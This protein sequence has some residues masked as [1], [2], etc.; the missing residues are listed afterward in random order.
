MPR[1]AYMGDGAINQGAYHE[2]LNLAELWDLPVIYIIENNGYSMGT[3]QERSSAHPEEGL[4]ASAAGYGI[5]WDRR[6][7]R[8]HLRSPR[9][10]PDAPSNAPTTNAARPSSSSTPTATTVTASLMRMIEEVPHARK[11]S[12][13]TSNN[14][15]RSASGARTRSSA[16][17]S[18]TTATQGTIEAEPR[19][20]A[21]ARSSLRR[22]EPAS[23]KSESIYDDVYWEVDQGTE[24]GKDRQATSST[25]DITTSKL[26][27]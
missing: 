22:A 16:K 9:R 27:C 15:T 8:R 3:S 24:A 18:S 1:S 4:A 25:T 13:V 20:S 23:P 21:K 17:A 2:S 10:H 6:Q 12:N 26:Y 7:R 14:T 11:R 19:R 5:E